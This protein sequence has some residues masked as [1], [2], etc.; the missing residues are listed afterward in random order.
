MCCFRGTRSPL[1]SGILI[2]HFDVLSVCMKH[3]VAASLRLH[4]METRFHFVNLLLSYSS[5][6][7]YVAHHKPDV[8]MVSFLSTGIAS[9]PVIF[10]F[11]LHFAEMQLHTYFIYWNHWLLWISDWAKY[12]ARVCIIIVSRINETN[13]ITTNGRTEIYFS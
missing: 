6:I 7:A 8:A 1:S 9:A 11:F 3:S 2:S 13:C 5:P 10:M 4:V 12:V